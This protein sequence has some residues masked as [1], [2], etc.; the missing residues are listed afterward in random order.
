MGP[1]GRCHHSVWRETKG[2]SWGC[3]SF[4]RCSRGGPHVRRARWT[5]GRWGP[6][7]PVLRK[8]SH[9]DVK[10]SGEEHR[11][12]VWL[13][14]E[15]DIRETQGRLQVPSVRLAGEAGDCLNARGWRGQAASA[16]APGGDHRS[17]IH[18]P[19]FS[20]AFKSGCPPEGSKTGGGRQGDMLDGA[21]RSKTGDFET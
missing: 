17:G 9:I 16:P 3:S 21:G 13:Q 8:V 5:G 15:R 4:A 7:R 12:A 1:G 18:S 19:L 10:V 14:A 11:C 20:Y 6:G 2:T